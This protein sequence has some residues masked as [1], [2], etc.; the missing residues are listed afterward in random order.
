MDF[1]IIK[2]KA[3]I[4]KSGLSEEDQQSLL[5]LFAQAKDG[6]LKEAVKLFE[7][8]LENVKIMDDVYKA[9]LK[10]FENKDKKGWREILEEERRSLEEMEE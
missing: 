9:K 4:L 1:N 7:N 8:D 10:V 5:S 3:L 2:I 6:D